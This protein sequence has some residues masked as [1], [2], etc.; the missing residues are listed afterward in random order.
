[1]LYWPCGPLDSIWLDLRCNS[2]YSIA[3]TAGNMFNRETAVE[4]YRRMR[5]VRDFELD[6]RR[7]WL[8]RCQEIIRRDT[9]R[10]LGKPIESEPPT[11]DTLLRVCQDEPVDLLVLPTRFD[12]WYSA[13]NGRV[14]IYDA[15]AIRA[16]LDSEASSTVASSRDVDSTAN[17][18]FA[19]AA[20]SDSTDRIGP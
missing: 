9:E 14:F 11:L 1:M 8:P 10:L 5:L 13:T 3:Q 2:Y 6:V 19:C 18:A 15:H 7:P 4:G 16:R 20:H 12:G 17:S